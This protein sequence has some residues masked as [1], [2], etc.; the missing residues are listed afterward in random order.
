MGNVKNCLKN[1]NLL[2][3]NCH[4]CEL[5]SNSDVFVYIVRVLLLLFRWILTAEKA[6]SVV[7]FRFENRVKKIY[8]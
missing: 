5:R 8:V 7:I 1:D 6:F 2:S 3:H 4:V